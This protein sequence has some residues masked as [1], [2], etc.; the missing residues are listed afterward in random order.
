MGTALDVAAAEDEEEVAPDGGDA[1]RK[2]KGRMRF[3]RL[4][5]C[6]IHIIYTHKRS[7]KNEIQH[8]QG[9]SSGFLESARLLEEDSGEH[10]GRKLS[11]HEKAFVE[12]QTAS[13]K[14]VV[15]SST[16]QA[17]CIPRFYYP[18]GKPMTPTQLDAHLLKVKAAFASLRDGRATRTNFSAIIR[19]VLSL[20]HGRFGQWIV[21]TG[22]DEPTWFVKIL[23]KAT[24]N[25]L[26]PEDFIPMMQVLSLLEEEEDINQITEYFSYEHFYV[27]YCKFWELDKDHDL[28]ID[29]Y[30]LSRHN[31]GAISMRMIDRIFSGA[32]TRASELQKNM[33]T[34]R[35]ALGLFSCHERYESA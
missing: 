17:S 15:R 22:R 32:V 12:S 4:L 34:F 7:K 31:E 28:Y 21:S 10:R 16:K 2:R 18:A 24:R 11:Q 25:Y 23:S 20:L 8:A 35:I 27:I 9:L 5:E 33:I 30:D 6:A 14:R 26:V 19:R 29:R 1:G 13:L 3:R